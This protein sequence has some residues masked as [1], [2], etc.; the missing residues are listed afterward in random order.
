MCVDSKYEE[1]IPIR[2]SMHMGDV[3]FVFE[4]D[5]EFALTMRLWMT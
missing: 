4:D 3:I 5:D 2:I 1:R